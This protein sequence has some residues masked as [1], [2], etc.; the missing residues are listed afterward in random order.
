MRF[1]PEF[2]RRMRSLVV[3][4]GCQTGVWL[5]RR[6]FGCQEFGCQTGLELSRV[7]LSEFGCQTGLELSQTRAGQARRYLCNG[8]RNKQVNI[9]SVPA[10]FPNRRYPIWAISVCPA[11][12]NFIN[13]RGRWTGHLFQSRFASVAMDELH[14]LAA[15]SY[16]SLNPVRAGLAKNAGWA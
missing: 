2:P 12:P 15:T 16:V 11:F 10:W 7:W 5:S 3:E 9:P 4:F 13:A 14:L 8:T 6:E 1:L